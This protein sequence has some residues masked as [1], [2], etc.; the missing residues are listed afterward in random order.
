[1][2]FQH[3]NKN[4]GIIKGIFHHRNKNEGILEGIFKANKTSMFH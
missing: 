4:V 3:R 2:D 1:M